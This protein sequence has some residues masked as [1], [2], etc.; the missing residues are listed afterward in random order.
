MYICTFSHL[1]KYLKGGRI[2]RKRMSAVGQSK[3]K[4]WDTAKTHQRDYKA[5]GQ[6]KFWKPPKATHRQSI[7]DRQKPI[8]NCK[9]SCYNNVLRI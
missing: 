4:L 7:T 3:E 8:F 6:S 1:N 5:R 2:R 9:S